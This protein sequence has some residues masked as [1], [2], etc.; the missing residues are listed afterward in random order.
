MNPGIDR[1]ARPEAQAGPVDASAAESVR[2]RL[3]GPVDVRLGARQPAL[4]DSARAESLLAYLLLHRDAPQPRQRVAFAL[5]PDS[6]ERQAQ[7][8]L[9]KVLH[10]LRHAVP[11]VGQLLDVGLRT[12]QWRADAPVW[13]DVEQ[14]TRALAEGRLADAV[15]LYAGELLEGRYDEWL[16]QE[17]S[18]LAG[19]FLEALERL[20]RQYEQDQ[21][22]P[23]AI[24]CAER[25]VGSDPLREESHRLLMRLCHASGDRARAVRVYHVCATVLER[26]LGIVP[27]AATQALYEEL[28]AGAGGTGPGTAPFVGRTAARAR[29]AA[30]WRAATS[31]QAQLALVTGEAGIGKTRLVDE[32]RA[33]TSAVAVQARAY[34]A[35]GALAYGVVAAWLRSDA[36][37]ARMSRLDRPHL[38]EL[39][40]LLPE[41]AA[42]VPPPQPRPEAELRRRLFEAVTRAL[43]AAGEPLL[44][45]LDDAHWADAQTLRVA[46]Y[47]LRTAPSARVLVAVTARREELDGSH[48][49]VGLCTAVQ[50]LGRLSEIVLDRFD[51]TETAT[52]AERVTGQ[53]LA[54]ADLDRLYRDSEGNPLFVIEALK[55]DAPAAAPRV[56]AVIAGRL[57]RLSPAATSLAGVAAA[58][59]RAFTADVLAA[60]TGLA[61]ES[62]VGALDELWR[63]GIV[64]ADGPNAYDFSHG[65]IRDAAYAMLS[66][67]QRRQAHLTVARALE[68]GRGASPA[69]LAQQYEHAG[70][71]G[72]AIRWHERA[73][74]AA[75]W[76]HAH[77]EAIHA[78]DRALAL[79]DTLPA[80]PDAAALRLRLLTAMPAALVAREG[81]GG[82]LSGL[83]TRALHLADQLGCEPEPPLMWSVAMAAVTR[84]EWER[85]RGYAGRLRARADRDGDEVLRVECDYIQG[86][87]AYWPGHLVQARAH[88]EAAMSRFQPARRRA[89]VLRYGQDPELL[90]RLRLAHTL[91]LLGHPDDADRE[92]DLALAAAAESSHPYSRSVV[93]VWAAILAAERSDVEEFRHHVRALE[94]SIADDAPAQVR[95]PAEAFAGY[96]DIVDGR[97]ETGLARVRTIR[98]QLAHREP[99]A[100]GLPG[101][102]TRLLLDGYARAGAA[103]AG[104]ALTD[105]ALDMGNGAQLWEAEIR[106][107]RAIFLSALGGSADEA[108]AELKRA[109]SVARRQ[110]ARAFEDRIRETLAER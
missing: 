104:L 55:P 44:L 101:V 26:E 74:E 17:R 50:A 96:L 41:L 107:L 42:H 86:I 72:E 98:E 106:R 6:T 13:L 19:L 93:S 85:A 62:F 68:Q 10:T 110:H 47:L 73:A 27:S 82:R 5:W 3:L 38:I 81:Y 80:G 97:T 31:G 35:E 11:D 77:A 89:H 103:Q 70:E 52:L 56:Q 28:V 91:W 23:E 32:L 53:P 34:P 87:A 109:L 36:V 78:F 92:R 58:I 4:L 1:K 30:R 90:V 49:L 40:R 25:V 45:I 7:T 76:L 12:L 16:A 69:A 65:R 60:A 15:E 61:D 105:D 33:V 88:F 100:P 75:Q 64:R 51:R 14:F 102:V 21:D 59:G 95:M 83:H 29:L 63:R 108:A 66:P 99:P 48:P 54:A 2:V 24:R 8:N 94:S 84:G 46:H 43:L 39:A 67:P 18:R 57:A 20:A 22:W 9:R 37:A 71:T 79:S